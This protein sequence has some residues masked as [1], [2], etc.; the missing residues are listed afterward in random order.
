MMRLGSLCTGYGGLDLGAAAWY[1]AHTVW[2]SDIDPGAA[3]II[4]HRY[5][6]A[7]NLGDLTRIDWASIPPCDIL[8]TGYPC[9][10]FSAAGRR[11]GTDDH[12]HLW[13]YIRDAIRHLR[14]AVTLLENVAGHRSLGFDRVLGDMAEDGLHARWVSVR[15]S[16][17]GAP[18][19]RERVFIAV[20]DPDRVRL[21]RWPAGPAETPRG[22]ALAEV[23]GPDQRPTADSHSELVRVEPVGQPGRSGAAVAG[24][25]SSAPADT[26]THGPAGLTDRA[27][28][29]GARGGGEWD[30][31]GDDR[32][33][34]D[35][36]TIRGR[37]D[38]RSPDSL[39]ATV[40]RATAA[41]SGE[42]PPAHAES[43]RR[44]KGRPQP[45]GIPRRPDPDLSRTQD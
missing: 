17:V 12:R 33:S 40:Q 28:S 44:R 22:G 11:K 1:G 45:E 9:Q 18:H 6:A 35:A 16:D 7:P 14:P 27:G 23:T 36:D 3:K 41:G 4:A 34:T 31:A 32:L 37:L 29:S 24:R 26:T 13:P 42:E 38:G 25:D 21:D 15:A 2:T 10:P 5:P 30:S 19:T 8:T 39:G 20:T 43:K